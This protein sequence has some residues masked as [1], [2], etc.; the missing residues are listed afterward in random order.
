MSL[1][2][3]K[4]KGVKL[5]VA[6]RNGKLAV[7][8][9]VIAEAVF[10]FFLYLAIAGK[11]FAPLPAGAQPGV[12]DYISYQGRLTDTSGNP[13]GGAGSVYCFRYSIWDAQTSGNQLWPAGTPGNSTTTVTDGIFSDQ[14]GRIDSLATLDFMSTSTYY[15]QVQVSTSS[16][17]CA[18]GLE[19]LAPR[20]QIVS[21]AWSQT[22]SNVYG[23]SI[24]TNV[25]QKVQIGAA[26]AGQT[27]STLTFLS[28]DVN[29]TTGDE[30]INGTC[31]F[32]GALW[33]DSAMTRALVC[34]AGHIQ[35]ISNA[36]TTIAGIQ[37]GGA[38][39]ISSGVVSISNVANVGITQNGNT[40]SLSAPAGGG[41]GATLNQ[42]NYPS[43]IW[44]NGGVIGVSTL[45][46]A[47]MHMPVAI[48]A[49]NAAIMV[50]G[51]SAATASAV[52]IAAS[53]GIYT[54]GAGASS[55]LVSLASSASFSTAMP[56]G[57]S[58]TRSYAGLR[59]ISMTGNFNFT[60]GDY[61]YGVL[62]RNSTA[63][64]S[65]MGGGASAY[66]GNVGLNTASSILPMPGLG[67]Y[68]VTIATNGTLP[69]SIAFSAIAA[70]GQKAVMPWIMFTSF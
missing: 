6:K 44:S 47:P 69:A 9:I 14:I 61:W 68:S 31:S 70:T 8:M 3:D 11:I 49:T 67:I 54:R 51:A 39:P 41:G 42:W 34:E 59:R 27:S 53:L 40:I 21:D 62:V 46:V 48:S 13:L 38:S 17:T 12:P 28:L 22:A 23:S 50:S 10:S 64:F 29:N 52:S 25:T 16:L 1:S 32:N 26:G 15:L 58:I 20:Q 63:T 33:Y 55:T 65:I 24:R 57:A 35:A 60:P 56:S 18:T 5:K 43:G 37:A 4:K 2:V 66:S 30:S 19:T 36:S 45:A 7:V